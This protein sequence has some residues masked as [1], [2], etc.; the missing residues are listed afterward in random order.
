MSIYNHPTKTQGIFNPSN[1]GGLGT[2]GQ[3]TTDYLD[4]NYLSFPVAQ[5][6][7]T[8]V[9]ASVF[10]TISQQQGDFTTT[11]DLLVNDV[12]VITEIG[13]KQDTIEDGD[14]TIAKTNGLQT[15]LND[16]QNDIDNTTDITM[17]D[18]I[19]NSVVIGTTNVITALGGKQPTI[20]TDDLA[21]TD[22]AGLVTALGGKQPTIETDDLAITDTAGLSTALAGKQPTIE[23][24]DLT[25]AKTDGLQ[26]ALDDKYDKAGGAISGGVQISGTLAPNGNIITSNRLVIQSGNTLE[27][28]D[29]TEVKLSA[30]LI[31]IELDS[32]EES[33]TL[34]GFTYIK[35]SLDIMEDEAIYLNEF[36]GGNYTTINY[37]NY[38]KLTED[39]AGKQ[40]E[41]QD[42][43]LTIAKT[44]G[45]QT[46]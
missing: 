31:E 37:F 32:V 18:L 10:G 11:G 16:K 19:A 26:T 46:A 7:T 15:A 36:G 35:G 43:D 20:E 42:G 8:L 28:Q 25:I 24:G 13:T 1:Y 12:N 33:I 9:G 27:I 39:V 34:N 29:D 6:N 23:D 44:D 3:I 2:G 38:N 5:G 14:L 40:D 17:K 4:A 45:L 30:G 41:I 22:T 21:I